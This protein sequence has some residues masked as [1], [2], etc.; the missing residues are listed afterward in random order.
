ML[1]KWLIKVSNYLHDWGSLP[2]DERICISTLIGLWLSRTKAGS[3]VEPDHSSQVSPLVWSRSSPR[4]HRPPSSKAFVDRDHAADHRG[5]EKYK[6][7]VVYFIGWC[8][9]VR[10]FDVC[11]T[12]IC[13]V[14]TSQP[15]HR[16]CRK[17][18]QEIVLTD[19][20]N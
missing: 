13:V 9:H 15:P 17:S 18:H 1:A 11:E 6:S 2:S 4:T 3:Q 7:I 14:G 12:Y 16:A 20:T 5:T 19:P 8:V 10:V